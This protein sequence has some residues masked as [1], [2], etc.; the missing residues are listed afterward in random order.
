MPIDQQ[1]DDKVF[2]GRGEGM[3]Q[4]SYRPEEYRMTYGVYLCTKCDNKFYGLGRALHIASCCIRGYEG[5]CYCFGDTENWDF[6]EFQ[7]PSEEIIAKAKSKPN[8][9]IYY[10]KNKF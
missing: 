3:L 6:L 8:T 1:C 10:E 7:R 9:I 4:I 5:T 2:L